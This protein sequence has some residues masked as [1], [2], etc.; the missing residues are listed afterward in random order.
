[1]NDEEKIAFLKKMGFAGSVLRESAPT[2]KKKMTSKEEAYYADKKE[3][4]QLGRI[5]SIQKAVVPQKSLNEF[6]EEESAR[7]ST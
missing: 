2:S 7:E 3:L 1:M 5:F 4:L 6:L